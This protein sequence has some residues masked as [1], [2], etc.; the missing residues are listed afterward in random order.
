MILEVEQIQ[1]Y[2][3]KSHIVQGVSLRVDDG[4]LDP[5]IADLALDF[6]DGLR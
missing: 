5:L 4:E 6:V 1:G 3:E 2:Y